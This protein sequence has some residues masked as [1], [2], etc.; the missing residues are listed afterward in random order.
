MLA[1]DDGVVVHVGVIA[2]VPTISIQ[3]SGGL[4]STYQPVTSA[5]ARGDPVVTAQVVGAL[6]ASDGGHC[7]PDHC[8]HLGALL[9]GSYVDPMALLRPM[10]VRLF[11]IPAA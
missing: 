9:H 5:L 1:V 11:P 8:L 10:V 3:H 2:A 4:R 6:A 7:P